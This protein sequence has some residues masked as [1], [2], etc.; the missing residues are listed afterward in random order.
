M[1]VVASIR[2]VP[3]GQAR[4]TDGRLDRPVLVDLPVDIVIVL[5]QQERADQL[6]PPEQAPHEQ[7]CVG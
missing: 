6:Q 2:L 7:R 4:A 3:G 1:R 5:E